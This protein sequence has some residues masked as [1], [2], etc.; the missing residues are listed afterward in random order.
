MLELIWQTPQART[1]FIALFI[2]PLAI[3]GSFLNNRRTSHLYA[4]FYNEGR[5]SEEKMQWYFTRDSIIETVIDVVFV[6]ILV[7]MPFLP[8]I[9]NLVMGMVALADALNNWSH[10]LA[11]PNGNRMQ[12]YVYKLQRE[13][14]G[15]VRRDYMTVVLWLY[16]S[17]NFYFGIWLM[18]SFFSLTLYLAS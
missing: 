15:G 12:R 18:F 6:L 13:A 1:F 14:N 8:L 7:F 5:F 2:A 9:V 4:E 10:I 16:Y 3:F 17:R 11:N